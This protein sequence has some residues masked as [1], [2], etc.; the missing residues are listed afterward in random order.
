MREFYAKILEDYCKVLH[1]K[2]NKSKWLSR[3]RAFFTQYPA[4]ISYTFP[5]KFSQITHRRNF[6][7]CSN[8]VIQEEEEDS[9]LASIAREFQD[10][11]SDN[12]FESPFI[13]KP[14]QPKIRHASDNTTPLPERKF[15]FISSAPKVYTI[16]N[17]C[18]CNCS[19]FVEIIHVIFILL[20]QRSQKRMLK[21]LLFKMLP[22]HWINSWNLTRN[23]R[24]LNLKRNLIALKTQMTLSQSQGNLKL[25]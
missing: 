21:N 24:I 4:I 9:D 6:S 1:L 13:K 2:I 12:I 16:E 19:L 25:Y 7:T 17:Y 3:H 20:F 8:I 11:D 18:M 10:D 14:N 22:R 5:E 15:S 23:T